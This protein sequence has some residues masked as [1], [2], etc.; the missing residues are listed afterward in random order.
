MNS[1]TIIANGGIGSRL[2][3]NNLLYFFVVNALNFPTEIDF[4]VVNQK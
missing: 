2:C 4:K 1:M 3:E